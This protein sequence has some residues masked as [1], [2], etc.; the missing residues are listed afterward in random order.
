MW[1]AE[2]KK[3]QAIPDDVNDFIINLFKLDQLVGIYLF[4]KEEWL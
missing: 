2:E 3:L 4:R 1:P